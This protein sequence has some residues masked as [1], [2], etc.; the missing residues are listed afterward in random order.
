MER[1][2]K[3]L[4]T[5]LLGVLCITVAP[6]DAFAGITATGDVVPAD[7]ATWTSST[8]AYVGK[9]AVGSVTVDGNSDVVSDLA[10][11]GH[12]ANSTGEVT[13]DGAGSTWT[14][15]SYLYVG[16]YGSGTLNIA[17]GGAVSN[18]W[19][20]IGRYAGSTGVV[21]VDGAGSTWT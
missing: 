15:S 17:N 7:P 4:V 5:V 2:S 20:Y 13:V 14:N 11:V 3:C 9:T 10:Y 16:R 6:P 12:D 19:G 1:A 21:T 8:Y 18:S